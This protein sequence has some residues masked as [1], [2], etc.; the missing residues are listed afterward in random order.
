MKQT[1]TDNPTA[2]ALQKASTPSTIKVSQTDARELSEK[3]DG[4]S[5]FDPI[6][7]RVEDIAQMLAISSRAAYNLCNSTSAFR[8]LHIGTSIRVNKESFDTWFANA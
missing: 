4:K 5:K 1:L 2:T 3:G 6:V 8:V 7:Y